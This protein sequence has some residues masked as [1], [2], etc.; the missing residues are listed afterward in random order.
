MSTPPGTIATCGA[1]RWRCSPS[2]EAC[3]TAA[4]RARL[5]RSA[6][7]AANSSDSS[8]PCT[9]ASSG[10]RGAAIATATVVRTDCVCTTSGLNSRTRACSARSHSGSVRAE[11]WLSL[12]TRRSMP[13]ASIAG[14]SGSGGPCAIS[15]AWPRAPRPRAYASVSRSL[16]PRPSP[17]VT[18]RMRTALTMVEPAAL[19]PGN[20]RAGRISLTCRCADRDLERQLGQ[21]AAAA[22]AA[23]AG[24]ARAG[25][26]LPAGDEA[27][28]RRVRPSCSAT[29]SRSAA[30]RSRRTARRPGTA[31]RSSRASGSRTWS[32][33]FAGRPGLPAPGGARG[34][35]DVRRRPGRLGLRA[36]RPHPGLRPLPL[37][38][39]LA[40]LAARAGRGR[41]GGD[42][43][44]RRHEH[45]ADRRGRLRPRGLRRPDPRHAAR[46]R[47]AGGARGARAPRRRARP[48]AARA[49]VHLLGLPRRD[50]PPGPRD[51]HR[52][53][54]RR[55]ARSP[56]AC[57]PPGST[58]RRARA[59]GRAT[60]RR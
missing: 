4:T 19:A 55:R 38:A 23:V 20:R 12:R 7:A 41:P 39:R 11:S 44:V 34:G 6:S 40:G 31:W 13:A 8:M 21:A 60:T 52:P 43:R 53:R 25:R 35:G 46:A 54:P 9:V 50:V 47:G 2:A 42:G 5:R 51:A 22:P 17:G 30:T 37:Q 18:K 57:G 28:R 27:R 48:L 56:S 58:A 26:R 24:R 33:G 45:R 14:A 36:E 59:R 29:S 16:P 1:Q 10:V 15:V 3:E 32:P 49:R